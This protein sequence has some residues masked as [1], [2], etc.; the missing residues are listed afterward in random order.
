LSKSVSRETPPN[1][2]DIKGG[3]VGVAEAKRGLLMR[4]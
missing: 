3:A 2:E 4:M 1:A